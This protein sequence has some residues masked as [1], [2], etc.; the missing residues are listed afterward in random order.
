MEARR[1]AVITGLTLALTVSSADAA[2]FNCGKWMCRH[3]GVANC[4][5]LALALEW[6]RK[7]QRVAHPAPGLI[8]VQRRKGRALGGGPGGHVSK[9]VSVTGNCRAIVRDNRGQYERDICKNRV[10]LVSPS[11]MWAE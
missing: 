2:S 6:A 9:I 11:G 7:F 5:S 1:I 4:G 10:A 3:V 8:L